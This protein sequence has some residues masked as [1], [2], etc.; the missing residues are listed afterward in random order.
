MTSVAV[1]M[2]TYNG[3]KYLKEQIDSILEQEGVN[4]RLYVRDDGSSDRTCSILEDYSNKFENISYYKGERNL[5]SCGSFFELMSKRYYEDYYALADQDDIWDEDKLKIAVDKLEMNDNNA[6]ALYYANQR[7]VD[8]RG[9][10]I[11]VSHPKPMV[12]GARYSFLADVFVT[13]C[14]TLYNKRFADLIACKHPS[15]FTMHDT[16]LYIVASLFGELYYDFEPHMSY[17]IHG[18]NVAGPRKKRFGIES[19]LREIKYLFDWKAQPRYKGACEIYR[20]FSEDLTEEQK[21]K[22]CEIIDYKKTIKG[23]L[24]L[25]LDSDFRSDS[26]YRNIRFRIKVLLRNI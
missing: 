8:S 22:I 3:E 1:L 14:T 24:R 18:D 2:S 17:R 25:L 10:F 7:V 13:G 19:A 23:T 20:Q 12:P 4:V 6:I 16:W 5:G 9:D 21:E 15:T 26:K 11:R